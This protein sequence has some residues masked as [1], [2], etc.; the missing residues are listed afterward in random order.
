MSVTIAEEVIGAIRELEG[1]IIEIDSLPDNGT[2]V[3]CVTLLNKLLNDYNELGFYIASKNSF[4]NPEMFK[5]LGGANIPL[6]LFTDT[7]EAPAEIHKIIKNLP[8]GIKYVVIDDFYKLVLHKKRGRIRT[9]LALL[10]AVSLEKGI[11][12]LLVNQMRYN[13]PISFNYEGTYRPLYEN[14]LKA[15]VKLRLEAVRN[16]SEI[17]LKI[18]SYGSQNKFISLRKEA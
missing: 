4:M 16:G 2:S 10:R 13:G 7:E 6:A 1:E 9:F 12:I 14:Y 11:N 8:A 18:N 15:Y 17:E 5:K 3:S